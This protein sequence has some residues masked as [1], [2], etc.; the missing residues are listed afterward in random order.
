MQQAG[1]PLHDFA[2]APVALLVLRRLLLV[3]FRK[4]FV[5]FRKLLVPFHK[6]FH[7]LGQSFVPLDQPIQSLVYGHFFRVFFTYTTK[8]PAQYTG[9]M[10]SDGDNLL[11][12]GLAQIAPVWL[13][14][15]RTLDQVQC[16]VEEAAKRGCQL[17]AFGEALIPGYPFWNE[18]TDGARCI[19][20]C[21]RPSSRSTLAV[22]L[23][24]GHLDRLRSTAARHRIAVYLSCIE[25]AA[26]RGGHR[27][28]CSL[29]YI[30]RRARPAR[31]P[32]AGAPYEER[33][34]R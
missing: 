32:E 7:A 12:L 33:L 8:P 20:R 6:Q 30:D 15:E 28:Y 22:R 19:R 11:T 24:A 9:P 23:E 13:D 2:Q 21:R 27:L 25:R 5:L 29:V 26:D 3:L 34:G 17:L 18:L 16:Y 31:A 1:D 14:R 4:L 10:D